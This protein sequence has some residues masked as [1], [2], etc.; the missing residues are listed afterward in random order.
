MY[1][2]HEK[3]VKKILTQTNKRWKP[4]FFQHMQCILIE[5]ILQNPSVFC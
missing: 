1:I 5:S 3:H 4:T 2:G